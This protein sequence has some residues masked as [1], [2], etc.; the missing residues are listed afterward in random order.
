[1]SCLLLF[2]N[3]LEILL[4]YFILF[5]VYYILDKAIGKLTCPFTF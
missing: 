5:L 2:I 4:V 1:M 3:Y